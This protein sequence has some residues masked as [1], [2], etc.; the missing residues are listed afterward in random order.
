MDLMA[1]S[2]RTSGISPNPTSFTAPKA[3]LGRSE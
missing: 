2:T 1:K 3:S